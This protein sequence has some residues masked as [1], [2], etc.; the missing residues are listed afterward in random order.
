MVGGGGRGIVHFS[1]ALS[2][3]KTGPMASLTALRRSSCLVGGGVGVGLEES[4][5]AP[6][7]EGAER[8]G[9][10]TSLSEWGRDP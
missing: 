2:L 7:C 10:I 1:S 8:G 9:E 3:A 4:P 5:Q 6:G